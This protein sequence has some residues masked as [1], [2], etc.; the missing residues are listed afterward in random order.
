MYTISRGYWFVM[1]FHSKMD[2]G[3]TQNT[4]TT[5]LTPAW[6]SHVSCETHD[7]STSSKLAD[8]FSRWSTSP[9]TATCSHRSRKSANTL[10]SWQSYWNTQCK[11]T[12]THGCA[13][14]RC[15]VQIISLGSTKYMTHF[16]LTYL[17]STYDFDIPRIHS[18]FAHSF[19]FLSQ[20]LSVCSCGA[21]CN[22]KCHSAN[23]RTQTKAW[24][25]WQ[26]CPM[27]GLCTGLGG[28]W[29][30]LFRPN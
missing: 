23:Q 25:H 13:D 2:S 19:P 24:E 5:T 21:S 26:N 9:L 29:L 3:S 7:T 6:R 14:S 15:I 27:A 18:C 17:V 28:V 8:W 4:V 30:K 16:E 20:W 22:E 12:G 11:N 1:F 10:Y